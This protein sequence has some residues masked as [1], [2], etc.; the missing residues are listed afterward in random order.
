MCS[1]Q[2]DLRLTLT[3]RLRRSELPQRP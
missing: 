1:N 3:D 2:A